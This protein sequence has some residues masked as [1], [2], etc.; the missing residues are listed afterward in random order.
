MLDEDL[1]IEVDDGDLLAVGDDEDL[2]EAV[3]SADHV[4]TACALISSV[5]FDGL[6][7][8][9]LDLGSSTAAGPSALTRLRNS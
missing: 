7:L 5:S 1:A 2:L 4:G 8:G 3:L 9:R 6:D